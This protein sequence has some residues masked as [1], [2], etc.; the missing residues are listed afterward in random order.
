MSTAR[1]LTPRPLRLLRAASL[2]EGLTLLALLGIGVPL[3]HSADLPQVVAILGPV[4][5]MAF[6]VYLWA[7]LATT[8]GT[9]GWRGADIARLLLS[10]FVPFGA[11]WTLHYLRKKERSLAGSTSTR[12][13]R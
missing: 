7:V 6:L 4:H 13:S 8:S 5:G 2:A 12:D 10:A 11:W 1:P 9:P 3:K